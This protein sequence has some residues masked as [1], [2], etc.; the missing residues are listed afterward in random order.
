MEI[1][2]NILGIKAFLKELFLSNHFM[3]LSL[4]VSFFHTLTGHNH[5]LWNSNTQR[6]ENVSVLDQLLR[7]DNGIARQLRDTEQRLRMKENEVKIC[8]REH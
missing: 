7:T 3:H 4:S 1:F 2:R 8:Q 5:E 6:H